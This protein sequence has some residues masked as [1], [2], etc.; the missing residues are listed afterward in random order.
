MS[1]LRHLSTALHLA[2]SVT[3]TWSALAGRHV[4]VCEHCAE[5]AESHS[6]TWLLPW[7][8]D[9]RC[10]PELVALLAEITQQRAA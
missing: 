7:A 3:I 4:A 5:T 9:H 6:S 2:E 8:D 10:D 1:K